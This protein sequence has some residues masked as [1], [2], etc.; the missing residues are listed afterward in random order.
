MIALAGNKA[1]LAQN[2]RVKTEDGQLYSEENGLIFLE[3]SAKTASNVNELFVE[4][5]LLLILVS[6]SRS[7]ETSKGSTTENS[8]FS[9]CN[10]GGYKL[11]FNRW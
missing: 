4:I 1:D 7:K 5:G 8:G 11:D 9:N 6:Y 10:R 2:R 3:T